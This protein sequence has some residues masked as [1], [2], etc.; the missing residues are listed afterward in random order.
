[1]SPVVVAPGPS[2][3]L[4]GPARSQGVLLVDGDLH[5]EGDVEHA[6]LIVVRGAVRARGGA[7]RVRGALMAANTSGRGATI[8]GPGSRVS[9]SS[10]AVG[11]ALVAASRPTPIR[12]RSWM[13]VTQ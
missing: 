5:V 8:I 4:R 12:R 9:Y 10:C 13:E 2:L 11:R 1:V 3:T 6:G 7:L